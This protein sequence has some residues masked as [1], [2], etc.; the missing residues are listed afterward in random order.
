MK[1]ILAYPLSVLY[2]LYFGFL[3]CFFHVIQVLALRVFGKAIHKKSVDI[4]N[5]CLI[6]AFQILGVRYKVSVSDQLPL[7][8]SYIFTSNHQSTYDIPPLIWYLRKYWA[9]FISK[10]SLGK[11]IPSISYNLRHGGNVLINR[12]NPTEAIAKIEAFGRRLIQEKRSAVIFPEGT[13]SR[14][15]IPKKF[16]RSGLKALL[17][18]MPKAEVVPI[19]I[20]HS[21]KLAQ[22]NYFPFPLGVLVRVE[23]LDPIAPSNLTPDEIIDKAEAIIGK[24]MAEMA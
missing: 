2:Y 11:G 9:N 5:L 8:K 17:V 22:H 20:Q 6:G 10:D 13:R 23:I 15:A 16:H 12:K 7:G 14:S 3:L 18:N 4:L 24:R 19:A 21:W 1:K